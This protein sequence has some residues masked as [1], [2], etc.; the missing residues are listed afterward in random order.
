M[1]N[2]TKKIKTKRNMHRIAF[3][4]MLTLLT[5]CDGDVAEHASS[6]NH[7]KTTHTW[8]INNSTKQPTPTNSPAQFAYL[9]SHRGDKIVDTFMWCSEG[10]IHIQLHLHNANF[11]TTPIYINV[12]KKWVTGFYLE[13]YYST[14]KESVLAVQDIK[15]KSVFNIHMRM[16]QGVPIEFFRDNHNRLNLTFSDREKLSIIL[17]ANTIIQLCN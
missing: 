15:N 8:V 4:S 7:T 5:A 11:S 13:F 2:Q 1:I 14:T 3:F 12:H 16:A 9:Q 6:I 17:D 10:K